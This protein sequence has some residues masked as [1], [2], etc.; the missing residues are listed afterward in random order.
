MIQRIRRPRHSECDFV[1]LVSYKLSVD[2]MRDAF[3]PNTKIEIGRSR[4]FIID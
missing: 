4:K 1:I 2:H 3:E